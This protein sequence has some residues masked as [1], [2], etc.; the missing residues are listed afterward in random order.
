[1]LM[2]PKDANRM[3]DNFGLSLYWLHCPKIMGYISGF[4]E[5]EKLFN[6]CR[7]ETCFN[8]HYFPTGK[9][10]R[11]AH[12]CIRLRLVETFNQ[13]LYCLPFSSFYIQN[14]KTSLSL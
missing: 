7:D 6:T 12:T 5:I 4:L 3:A 9:T 11:T 14:F 13:E 10:E 2:S 1:M 8:S